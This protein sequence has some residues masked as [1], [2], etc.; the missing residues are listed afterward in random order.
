M[1]TCRDAECRCPQHRDEID[2][3]CDQLIETAITADRVF[4]RKRRGRR[5]L[6]GW[7]D[8]VQ[9]FKEDC[10]FWWT[11]WNESNR[12]DQGLFERMRESKRQYHYAVRRVKRRQEELKAEKFSQALI[13]NQSRDFFREVKKVNA[14][15]KESPF[16][17]GVEGD[18]NIA[19][20]F[21][22]KYC[23]L[24]NSVE[25]DPEKMAALK[26]AIETGSVATTPEMFAVSCEDVGKAINKLNSGKADGDRGLN[27][28]HLVYSSRLYKTVLAKL[29]TAMYFHGHQ[30]SALLNA[31][32]VSIP[33]NASRSMSDSSNYRGIA[34]CSAIAKTFDLI[35]LDRNTDKMK[36]SN[37]Q[38]AFKKSSSTT[39]C[40]L[41]LKEVVNYYLNR[42][43][44]VFACFLDA[45]KAFDRVRFDVLF[46]ELVQ[47]KVQWPDL[48]LLLDLYTRQRA[49]TSWKLAT[50]TYFNSA[51]GIRQGSIISPLLFCIYLDSII[52]ELRRTGVG[53][54][55]GQSY[56]GAMIYADDITLL[57]PSV[58]GLQQMLATAEIFSQK[59]AIKFNASKTVC[60]RFTSARNAKEPV[61][62]LGGS[63]LSWEKSTKHLVITLSHDLSEEAEVTGR[64][65]TFSVEST[66]C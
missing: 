3:W 64:G 14:R 47:R 1:S 19:Q 26:E 33:K 51:N 49:R 31:T 65:T 25:S 63:R 39:S 41:V 11:L 12:S 37:L 6:S 16:I 27:S 56:Y 8:E 34:L 32:I 2:A 36:T 18:H 17:D 10:V 62:E 20:H 22:Q 42:G 58:R 43:T 38:F 24:Y 54:H 35:F 21:M 46:E 7:N 9:A 61:V 48:R 55:I 40:S 60:I 53:C 52:K 15:L 30:A 50:S 28:N 4:P 57:S 45:T 66:P 13:L 29:F 44:D 5:R 59:R 23:V